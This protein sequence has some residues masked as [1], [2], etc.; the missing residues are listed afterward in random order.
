MDF[1]LEAGDQVTK[2]TEVLIDKSEELQKQLWTLAITSEKSDI[3][4]VQLALYSEVLNEVFDIHSKRVN[5]TFHNRI[6]KGIRMTLVIIAVCSM[7]LM[8]YIDGLT[9]KQRS[10]FA[11]LILILAFSAVVVLIV[12]LDRPPYTDSRLIHV[13]Q[14]ALASLRKDML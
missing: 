11:N 5:A 8:G 3:H 4:P 7:L 6:A 14:Q 2:K 9:G 1:R 12:D 10:Y 13:S